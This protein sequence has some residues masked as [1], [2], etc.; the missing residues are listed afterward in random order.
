APGTFARRRDAMHAAIADWEV[1]HE[2]WCRL[3]PCLQL[4]DANDVHVLAAAIAGH[5]DCIVTSNLKDFPE[6]L[7]APF[8]LQAIHPDEFLI[9]QLDLDELT[10][11]A[12]FKEQRRRLQRGDFTRRVRRRARAQWLGRHRAAAAR[13]RGVDL[14]M[15]GTCKQRGLPSP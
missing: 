14:N 11:L 15:R 4:P 9:A 1:P 3:V 5:A 7:L 10:V 6:Q 2:A 13:G 8:G 12:A